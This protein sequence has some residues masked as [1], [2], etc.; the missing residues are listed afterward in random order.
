MEALVGHHSGTEKKITNFELNETKVLVTLHPSTIS[1]PDAYFLRLHLPCLCE[2]WGMSL[3]LCFILRNEH[4]INC[5][6][7]FFYV[8][9]LI[10]TQSKVTK[11]STSNIFYLSY[12]VTA[13]YRG[14]QTALVN[15]IAQSDNLGNHDL[16]SGTVSTVSYFLHRYEHTGRLQPITFSVMNFQAEPALIEIS[17]TNT[18]FQAKTHFTRAVKQNI[19]KQKSS[20][21]YLTSVSVN[22]LLTLR[23]HCKAKFLTHFQSLPRKA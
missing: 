16:F 6:F 1:M 11:Q 3:K 5:C 17:A 13:K 19:L 8:D 2:K 15:A 12:A 4:C 9:I 18:S 14:L 20:S 21:A 22:I 23:I 7:I 10:T